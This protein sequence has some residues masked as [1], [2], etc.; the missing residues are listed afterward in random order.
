MPEWC[1]RPGWLS[2]YP[3]YPCPSGTK[4]QQC[5]L[6]YPVW[7]HAL[8]LRRRLPQHQSQHL[9]CAPAEATG[10]CGRLQWLQDL[11]PPCLLHV[12]CGGTTGNWGAC[13]LSAVAGQTRLGKPSASLVHWVGGWM[14][15]REGREMSFNYDVMKGTLDWNLK[16]CLCPVQ[17]VCLWAN[18]STSLSLHSFLIPLSWLGQGGY[19]ELSVL[20]Q[21][22]FPW[23]SCIAQSGVSQQSWESSRVYAQMQEEGGMYERKRIW[24]GWGG[25]LGSC[26]PR[27]EHGTISTSPS[28]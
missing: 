18:S 26:E 3:H 19:S 10:L 6:E 11:L 7:G 13:Q 27:K 12:G 20:R 15:R 5:S 21:S 17:P 24:V 23:E 4:C 2:P 25:S 28:S 22:V 9:P 16:P 14:M 8:L 1:W